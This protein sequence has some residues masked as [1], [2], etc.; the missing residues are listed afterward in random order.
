M[1]N[2]ITR[3]CGI[4]LRPFA[5]VDGKGFINVMQ[6]TIDIGAKYGNN[7]ETQDILPYGC[8]VSRL[9][10]GEYDKIN[11][12]SWKSSVRYVCP[13]ALF[14]NTVQTFYLDNMQCFTC[15]IL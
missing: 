11:K 1:T 8:T 4:D 5:V 2:K 6:E 15:D 9:V 12:W 14:Y 10:Q 13:V 3:M 7:V